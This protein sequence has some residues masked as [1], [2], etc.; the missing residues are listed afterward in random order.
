MDTLKYIKDQIEKA[1][2]IDSTLIGLEDVLT[3]IKRAEH[4]LELGKTKNDE[5]YYTD[6]IYRTNHAYEGIL[7][8][9]YFVLTKKSDKSITPN[10]IEKYLLNNSILHNRVIALLENYRKEWRNTST[11]DYQLFFNSGEAF[12]AILSVTSFIHLL[13]IQI[14]DKLFYNAEVE[15]IKPFIQKIKTKFNVDYSTQDFQTKI[16]LLL[17]SYDGNLHQ[18]EKEGKISLFTEREYL[19]GIAAH[20]NLIDKNLKVLIEPNFELDTNIRPDILIEDEN[21]EKAIIEIKV[22]KSQIR[23]TLIQS[24]F[25]QML[26]YLTKLRI[27]NGYIFFIRRIMNSEIEIEHALTEINI[28]DEKQNIYTLKEKN[29]R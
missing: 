14:L 26:S 16:N 4:L 25:N 19:Q 2:S 18:D 10:N 8:E 13:L 17:K 15:R 22:Y 29:R 5:H 7:K 9:A 28:G 3:H 20:I 23:Q 27:N 1:I 6:V 24:S 11:H 21:G 12:L